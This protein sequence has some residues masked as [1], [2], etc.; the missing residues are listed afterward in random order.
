[1]SV[2]G[3]VYV[4]GTW[5]TGGGEGFASYDPASGAELWSGQAAARADV[6]AAVRGARRAFPTWRAVPLGERRA[7]VRRY[8]DLLVARQVEL[9]A[10]LARET[11]K[12]RWEAASEVSAMVGK[13]ELSIEA[14][15]AR[16]GEAARATVFGRA[17][18]RHRPHGVLVVL[19][20]FNFPGHL[21]NG[22]IV[23]AL[24]AGNTVVFKPSE[25][26]PAVGEAM[27]GVWAEAGLPE[28]VLQLVQG[29]AETGA[30]LLDEPGLNGVLFTGSATTGA[31][32]HRAFGGRPEVILA[33]EMGGNNPLV[34]WE[35]RDVA[36]AA[37][38]VVQSAYVS[39]GQRCSCA[40]RLIVPASSVGDR[41]VRATAEL[42]AR[43]R[44]GCWDD[45]PQPFMGPLIN[46]A[47]AARVLAAQANL[48]ASGATPVLSCRGIAGRSGA[49]LTPGL[50]E[51]GTAVAPDEEVFG[52]LLT[53]RR[54][55]DF[56]DAIAI[57]NDT[58]FGLSAGLVADDAALYPRFADE[59]RAGVMAF[60]RPTTGAS[61]ALPF[62]GPGRSGNHRPSAWYAADYC[63]YPVASQEADSVVAPETPGLDF[64][65]GAR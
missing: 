54:A 44:V 63:A 51:L 49:F 33:L 64:G 52:P 43:V 9:A 26:T 1:M 29:G 22:H 28:G 62:G 16:T 14:Q 34:V 57:A 58:G 5:R 13:I 2:R 41:V 20:P 12:P 24:I 46:Q 11:G 42:A 17:R 8:R 53:V 40:R 59:V 55:Q 4:D 15:D 36:A 38:L 61:S 35:V 32:I 60:N 56:A 6:A 21:P 48:T 45:E 39:A 18:L 30:A 50:L 25:L 27:V 10:L 23:P 19:G 7:L 47:A 3:D 65:R 37:A 31:A